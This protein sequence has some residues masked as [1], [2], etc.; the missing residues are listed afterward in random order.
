MFFVFVIFCIVLVKILMIQFEE[1]DK[2]RKI[3]E[4]TII[5]NR[6]VPANKGNIYSADGSLLGTSMPLYDI[7]MDVTVV[8]DEVFEKNIDELSRKLSELLNEPAGYF[9]NKMRDARRRQ[10]K[11]ISIA[12][13]VNYTDYCKIKTFPILNK[14]RYGGG[15]KFKD[16]VKRIHPVG[17]MA[18]RTI[19]YGNDGVGIE[20]AF[21]KYLRGKDGVRKEQK[22]AR[23]RW[24]PLSDKNEI[25]PIDGQDV[26]T[27]LDVNIQDLTHHALLKNLKHFKAE[28]GCAVVMEVNSGEIKAMSNLTY[29]K[30]IRDYDE[31]MNYAVWERHNPGSTFKLA[32]LMVGIE[33]KVID[34][35][36]VINCGNGVYHLYGRRVVDAHRGLGKISIADIFRHSSNVGV[37]KAINSNYYDDPKKFVDRIKFF[38]LGQKTGIRINGERKPYLIDPSSKW[39]SKTSLPWMAFGYE[40]EFTPLQ[41]LTF[42]NAVANDGEL[43]KPRIVKEIRLGDKVIETIDKEVVN[44]KIARLSTINKM[45]KL[46]ADVVKKV[47]LETYILK[48]FLWQEKQVQHKNL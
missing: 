10:D 28:H 30:R 43:V 48:N 1:G 25:D 18:G 33:D 34:T 42:Y 27:T 8:K 2:Y 20:G 13:G 3:A 11:D 4:K 14:G 22:I 6:L 16:R 39:W 41:I 23:G 40:M 26:V 12:K 46:M 47:Q 44:K 31:E 5:T 24:K 38:G 17:Q 37:V 45:K 35:S 9:K 32:S 19:G 7:S 29:N 15:F 21:E 36:T